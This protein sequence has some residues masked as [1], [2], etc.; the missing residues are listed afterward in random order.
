MYYHL[1]GTQS[2]F[3]EPQS[4]LWEIPF[5]FSRRVEKLIAFFV[6]PH[7]VVYSE[8]VRKLSHTLNIKLNF[9]CKNDIEKAW[10]LY[11]GSDKK[12]KCNS[13]CGVVYIAAK[14][15]SYCITIYTK[16][17]LVH[18]TGKCSNWERHF[19]CSWLVANFQLLIKDKIG[20]SKP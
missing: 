6:F 3:G 12:I 9:R 5:F 4:E 18:F 20:D 11:M 7:S 10:A 8:S 14:H 2:I 15:L 16:W 19:Y 1:K 13:D 17:L